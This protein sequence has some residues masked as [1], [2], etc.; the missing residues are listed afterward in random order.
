MTGRGTWRPARA[1]AALAASAALAAAGAVGC[2]GDRPAGAATPSPLPASCAQLTA[3]VRPA[4]A[5]VPP[6]QPAMGF[7]PFNTFGTTFNQALIVAIVEAMAHNGMGAVGYRYIILDD[8]WQGRRNAKGQITADAR[9]FPCG[10]R[11]LAQFVHGQGFR[12][13]LYATSGPRSCAGRT[14]N[15]GHAAADARTFARWG[16][17]YIK[18]D[19]CNTSYAP[20]V[21]AAITRQWRA[22]I[23]ASH[24]PMVLSINAG[25]SPAVA[26]WAHGLANSWRVGGDV[27]GSWY[28]Q[29][30]PPPPAARR[31]YH[32][33]RYHMGIFDY[34]MSPVLRSAEGYAG[35]GHYIDP[36]ML[37]VG[38]LAEA[39]DGR[40]LKTD[41][42][43]YS[44]A[45]TNFS[46]WAMWSAPL[47]A[48]NDPRAMNGTDAASR[49]LLN[50]QVVAIDQDPRGVPASLIGHRGDW[51]IWHKRLSGGRSA[52]A[53]VNLGSRPATA[54]F[55]WAQLGIAGRPGS[56]S[57]LWA[58]RKLRVTAVLRQRL[59][60]HATG[61]YL[62]TPR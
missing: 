8:G 39:A 16:V 42:L 45:E 33:R 32:D 41:A 5:P 43:T 15:A 50:Q 53:I 26:P 51:Q 19:W 24:R 46:M 13:G 36:D 48:G 1:R 31:C 7:D 55:T 9:R 3:P 29:T 18:L 35:P 60:P 14:G 58:H 11:R 44:E 10:M 61:V 20:P 54:R 21:A 57:D 49:I 47:I 17:D 27:C 62:V 23:V 34:L 4:P 28:N 30:R 37:E 59:P 2:T 52:V 22:A 6:A 12:L 56:V 38:T 25:G 40:N